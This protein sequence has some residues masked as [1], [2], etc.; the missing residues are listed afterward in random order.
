M[1]STRCC[2]IVEDHRNDPKTELH[3]YLHHDGYPEGVGALCKQFVEWANV[4]KGV[5][6]NVLSEVG[7]TMACFLGVIWSKG[8]TSAYLTDNAGNHGDLE[9]I[10]TISLLSQG[11]IVTGYE[12][13]TKTDIPA[14][15]IPNESAYDNAGVTE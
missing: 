8:Y 9:Y 1:M 2:V 7:K 11:L 3:A 14:D 13:N 5:P 15:K 6:P 4:D 10:W 12:V